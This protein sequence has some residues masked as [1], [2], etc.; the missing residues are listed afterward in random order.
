[1][2]RPDSVTNEDILR[3]SETIDTDPLI[4][5]PMAQN[6]IIREVCYAGQWMADKLIEMDCPDDLIGRMMFTAGRICFGRKD[7]WEVHQELL[8]QFVDGVLEF[9]EDEGNF[10]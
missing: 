5:T 9:E 2:P 6:A 8:Q 4:P 3:W 7:P 10:N 1:M